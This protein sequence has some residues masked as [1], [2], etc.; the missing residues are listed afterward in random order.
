MIKLRMAHVY[1]RRA[2]DLVAGLLLLPALAG[3]TSRGKVLGLLNGSLTLV[4]PRI[5]QQV[6]IK[7]GLVCLWWLRL[8]SNI[9]YMTEAEADAQYLANRSV[10]QDM[11]ILLRAA[12]ACLYSPPVDKHSPSHVI[13]GLRLLNVRADDLIEA[14]MAALHARVPTRVAFVNP[15][16]VN[17]AFRDADY[18]RCL[19]ACD[20]VC[21][22][23]I[24]MK[25]AGSMLGY[26][27]C[28]NINGTDLFPRLCRQLAAT[29]QSVYLL[30][31]RDGVAAAT[32]RWATVH[33]P[34]LKIA[35]SA[36]GYF[37][38]EQEPAL[39]AAIRASGADMLLVALGAP[40]Q[41]KWLET[42]CAA[43]GA[44]VGMGVGG[45]FDYYSG[46]MPRAPQWMREIGCEW[47]FRLYQEPGR[48]WRRYL[49]GN[50]VFL[51]RIGCEKVHKRYS[52]LMQ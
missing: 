48:M 43:S 13:A 44:V 17:I 11:A 51:F 23:G 41:E 14:I 47:I 42:H 22:D 50:L 27:I 25:I 46:S 28:Q 1:Y 30:G 19:G 38:D 49:V 37:T 6:G 32:A 31:G 7:P 3:G 21:A 52:K 34:G 24:G 18:R 26:P 2:L 35:G 5:P 12:M 9:A 39:I 4:G 45:L 8:R 40:R 36:H 29:G 10:G 16:C 15:D 33:A 20:W